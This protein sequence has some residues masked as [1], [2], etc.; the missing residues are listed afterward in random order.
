MFN[1]K[2]ELTCGDESYNEIADFLKENRKEKYSLSI[3][4]SLEQSTIEVICS[5]DD[6]VDVVAYISCVE[7][8]FPMW[9]GVNELTESYVVGMEFTRGVLTTPSICK[10]KEGKLIKID[11]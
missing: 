3:Y 11:I 5:V 7:H 9:I 2:R 4:N 1:L 6:I 8:D 10:W